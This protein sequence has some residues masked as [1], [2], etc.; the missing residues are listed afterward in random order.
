MADHSPA[1]RAIAAAIR[2]AADQVVP[3][4]EEPDWGACD[5][6]RCDIELFTDHQRKR[7][8][9]L[10]IVAELEQHP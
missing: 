8:Q 7:S 9:L 2:A 10:A 6:M 5:H 3:E 4:L 1:T